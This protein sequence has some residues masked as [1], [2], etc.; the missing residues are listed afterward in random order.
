[1]IIKQR[2]AV[3]GAGSK[4]YLFLKQQA[5]FEDYT[6]QEFSLRENQFDK[7]DMDA[8]IHVIFSLS[9]DSFNKELMKFLCV[10]YP[11]SKK[12]IVGSSSILSSEADKY[13]YSR[14]KLNQFRYAQDFQVLYGIF[15][16]FKESK[17]LG[18]KRHSDAEYFKLALEDCKEGIVGAKSYYYLAGKNPESLERINKVFVETRLKAFLIKFCTRYT[19]GYNYVEK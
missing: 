7:Q 1:M 2:L 9:T 4:L 17:R 12:L 16:E 8:D 18:L 19:Y 5:T 15:G 11:E 6:V 14:T 3:I 10:Q 13:S